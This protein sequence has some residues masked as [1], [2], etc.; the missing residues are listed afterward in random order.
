M[1]AVRSYAETLG[2]P[3]T[4][5]GMLPYFVFDSVN[6]RVNFYILVRKRPGLVFWYTGGQL[7]QKYLLKRL[8]TDSAPL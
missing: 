7:L 4:A 8:S 1:G 2:H 3:W 5:L 6:H